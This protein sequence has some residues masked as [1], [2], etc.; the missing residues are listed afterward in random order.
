MAC[1]NHNKYQY[2]PELKTYTKIQSTV[3]IDKF[4]Y[5]WHTVTLLR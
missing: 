2:Q 3:K 4:N 1:K 5:I